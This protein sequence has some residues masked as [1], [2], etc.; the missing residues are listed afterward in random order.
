MLCILI[1]EIYKKFQCGTLYV[2]I[3]KSI[4]G[5]ELRQKF[6]GLYFLASGR[7]CPI[8]VCFDSNS[9]LLFKS[10]A[11]LLGNKFVPSH[12]HK[13]SEFLIYT[14]NTIFI[15]KNLLVFKDHILYGLSLFNISKYR[16]A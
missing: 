9:K 7:K 8:F 1:D 15:N 4:S 14:I 11:N 5:N 12:H 13:K 16:N 3:N 10:G 2:N 6:P